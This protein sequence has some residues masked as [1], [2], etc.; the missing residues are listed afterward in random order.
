MA[1]K[2]VR[3]YCRTCL[4]M[5]GTIVTVDEEEN[6]IVKIRPDAESPLSQG[7]IC[8]KGLS[9]GEQHNEPSRIL[10]P[11]K[12]QPDGSYVEIDSEQALDEIAEKL[13]TIIDR[14]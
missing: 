1:L 5:C 13:R 3:S 8:S 10:R 9:A 14:D 7:Y 2:E 4:A 11:L 6:R 12:R